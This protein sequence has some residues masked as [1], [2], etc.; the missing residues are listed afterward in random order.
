MLDPNFNTFNIIIKKLLYS[1]FNSFTF[2]PILFYLI[3]DYYDCY[4]YLQMYLFMKKNIK[5]KYSLPC[6]TVMLPLLI[7][8]NT[9]GNTVQYVSISY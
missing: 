1:S 4:Y 5:Y 7:V 6:A 2:V 9:S 3:F 8:P